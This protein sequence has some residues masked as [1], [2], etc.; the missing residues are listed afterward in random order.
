MKILCL[1]SKILQSFRNSHPGV[2]LGK[3]FLKIC[4][5]FTEKHPCRTAIL[6]KQQRNFIEIT[7][8]H[9]CSPVNLLHI[10]RTPYYKNTYGWLLLNFVL[11]NIV[12]TNLLTDVD[13]KEQLIKSNIRFS[14][15]PKC[16]MFLI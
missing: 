8:R 15:C 13:D 3:S 6:I 1:L 4:S 2:F 10:F 5:K 16:T 7:L 9:G 12:L 14:T 11:A